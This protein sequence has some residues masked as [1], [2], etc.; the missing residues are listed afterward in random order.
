MSATTRG[1]TRGRTTTSTRTAARRRQRELDNVNLDLTKLGF[2]GVDCMIEKSVLTGE[3]HKRI[4]DGTLVLVEA[5]ALIGDINDYYWPRDKYGSLKDENGE[6]YHVLA[7]GVA[8]HEMPIKR[9]AAI[10]AITNQCNVGLIKSCIESIELIT[11]KNGKI[12]QYQIEP[13]NGIHD[14]KW[15]AR[16]LT[17]QHIKLIQNDEIFNNVLMSM[18]SG[19][20][21]VVTRIFV[22]MENAYYVRAHSE[23]VSFK[24]WEKRFDEIVQDTTKNGQVCDLQIR[25]NP[26]Q[27]ANDDHESKSGDNHH[28]PPSMIFEWW[29]KEDTE[30]IP[31]EKKQDNTDKTD[32]TDKQHKISVVLSD[33]VCCFCF[34][35]CFWEFVFCFFFICFFL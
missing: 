29:A 15:G 1:K 19:C 25:C 20:Y 14:S 32:K 26:Y 27:Q 28:P 23:K 24:N 18:D 22:R 7:S 30:I 10:G 11:I 2:R 34:A 3:A 17:S 16:V 12:S 4:R 13:K 6:A 21:G 33:S 5:G 8:Y 9:Y 31:D 35:I